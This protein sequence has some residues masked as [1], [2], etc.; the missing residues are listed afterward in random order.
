LRIWQ[1]SGKE[2]IAWKIWKFRSAE[3]G[4][5][6]AKALFAS[7]SVEKY[8]TKDIKDNVVSSLE[9]IILKGTMKKRLRFLQKLIRVHGALRLTTSSQRTWSSETRKYHSK[10]SSK[11]CFR[12]TRSSRYCAYLLA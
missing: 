5:N 10:Q 3:Q 9:E 8:L 1:D 11:E 2:L 12:Q 6:I 7:V 4:V